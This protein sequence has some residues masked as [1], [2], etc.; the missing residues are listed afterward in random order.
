MMMHL[1]LWLFFLFM[2][3]W[4]LRCIQG[5]WGSI[6]P[7]LSD[8]SF[9]MTYLMIHFFS[10]TI[11]V[12]LYCRGRQSHQ[13]KWWSIYSSTFHSHVQGLKWINK[14]ESRLSAVSPELEKRKWWWFF[15]SNYSFCLLL[16]GPPR[17]ASY[18]LVLCRVV[19]YDMVVLLFEHSLSLKGDG[20]SC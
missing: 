6:H 14:R 17:T 10:L 1:F 16:H 9:S 12:W 20:Y 13:G 7:L 3:I 2:H 5:K 4:V 18:V 11:L 15:L 19:V 8:S